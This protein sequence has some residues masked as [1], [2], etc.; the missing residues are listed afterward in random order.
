MM[1]NPAYAAVG[2]VRAHGAFPGADV[3]PRP[4]TISSRAP[5][6]SALSLAEAVAPGKLPAGGHFAFWPGA[7]LLFPFENGS[8][9]V[10]IDAKYVVVENASAFNTYGTFGLAL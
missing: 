8:A 4:D 7:S 5:V 10:G 9:F 6:S 2:D 3:G 1:P